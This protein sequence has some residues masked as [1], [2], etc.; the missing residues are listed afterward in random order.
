MIPA[1]TSLLAALLTATL[2][3]PPL[4]AQ[5]TFGERVSVT[6]VEVPV[7]VLRN[8]EP[9][10][11]LKA[12]DFEVYDD[13][14]PRELSGFEVVDVG[15]PGDE[16]DAQ[17]SAAGPAAR[18][19]LLLLF[20]LGFSGVRDLGR[21]LGAARELLASQLS[22]QDRVAIATYDNGL[23]AQLLVG[24]TA[25]RALLGEHLDLLAALLSAK[26]KEIEKQRAILARRD[27]APASSPR[28]ARIARLAER[29]GSAGA[30]ALDG[31]MPTFTPPVAS[32]AALTDLTNGG[33]LGVDADGDRLPEGLSALGAGSP[34]ALTQQAIN[35]AVERATINR[36]RAF[37]HSL[38]DLVTLLGDVDG[39]RILLLLSNGFPSGALTAPALA[40]V[41]DELLA[42]FRRSGWSIHAIDLAGVPPSSAEGTSDGGVGFSANALLYLAKGTG[43]AVYENFNRLAA[44]TEQ[45]LTRTRLSYRLTFTRDDLPADGKFHRLDVRVKG[46]SGLTVVHRPGYQAPKPAAEQSEL[47]KRL[48]KTEEVLGPAEGGE[49][50]LSVVAAPLPADPRG[51]IPLWLEVPG[52][53]L[54]DSLASAPGA[55][56]LRFEV[57]AYLLR[58]GEIVT[59]LFAQELTLD[60]ARV[61]TDLKAHGLRFYGEL[62][63]PPGDYRLRVRV[64]D[65]TTARSSVRSVAIRVPDLKEAA[66]TLSPPFFLDLEGGWVVTRRT[67]GRETGE[68]HPYPLR[69]GN[70]EVL[71]HA[72]PTF[73]PG[74]K[75]AVLL[76]LKSGQGQ[77]GLASRVLRADGTVESRAVLTML[78]RSAPDADGLSTVLTTL[79]LGALP[80]GT[81]QLEVTLNT[82]DAKAP[83]T[84]TSPFAIQA[85]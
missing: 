62:K 35:I 36:V 82:T 74:S 71:P 20:D 28:A 84:V 58:D 34:T 69:L 63:A 59:D 2:L 42:S 31:E 44:A 14:K 65:L 81:Y 72:A 40:P 24:F 49:L 48:A 8:G 17:V 51:R 15:E 57:Q 43:G 12:A 52:A 46:E 5:G 38:G 6:V 41:L 4:L 76:L 61:A 85:R 53:S 37:S 30:L 7:Q 56:P 29:I 3:T 10:D 18:R 16:P 11:G 1:R 83:C 54:P 78:D 77:A 22:P 9:V 45:A 55:A 32:V 33:L 79:N 21:A 66:P 68:S 47:E 13:G 39:Q 19:N 50:A 67:S 70:R 64:E 75:H 26:P 60:P 23:G 27:E 80:A 73:A 25:D